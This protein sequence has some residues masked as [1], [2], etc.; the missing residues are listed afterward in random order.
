MSS[1]S[2]YAEYEHVLSEKDVIELYSA[3]ERGDIELTDELLRNLQF[4]AEKI[5]EQA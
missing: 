3:C 2:E 5:R 1:L 4:E